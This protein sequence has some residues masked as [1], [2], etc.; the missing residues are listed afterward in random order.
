MTLHITPYPR[1]LSLPAISPNAPPERQFPAQSAQVITASTPSNAS[2]AARLENRSATGWF[3]N[4]SPSAEEL[5]SA[6]AIPLPRMTHRIVT[7]EG[8]G[9]TLHGGRIY[10]WNN[11][12]CSWDRHAQHDVAAIRLG[13]NGIAYACTAQGKLLSLTGPIGTASIDLS[14]VPMF[15]VSPTGHIIYLDNTVSGHKGL[16]WIQPMSRGKPQFDLPLPTPSGAGEPS[17]VAYS[18]DGQ[19]HLLDVDGKLWLANPHDLANS[20][21]SAWRRLLEPRAARLISLVTLP[22]GRVGGIAEADEAMFLLEKNGAWS[23]QIYGAPSGI[24]RTYGQFMD[25]RHNRGNV[26]LGSPLTPGSARVWKEGMSWLESKLCV[27][28]PEIEQ[29]L[30]P[31]G[32]S[33]EVALARPANVLERHANYVM[34]HY[35]VFTPRA[36]VTAVIREH[37]A[38]GE[39]FQASLKSGLESPFTM[40]GAMAR[41][42]LERLRRP[43]EAPSPDAL[44]RTL[45][46]D[47]VLENAN[48]ALDRLE[49]ALDL[50]DANGKTQ[51]GRFALQ[52]DR[53]NQLL[54][55]NTLHD[56]YQQLAALFPARE[57]GDQVHLTLARLDHLVRE[58]KL[59]FGTDQWL[60][61][62]QDTLYD[63]CVIQIGK[64]AYDLSVACNALA[65]FNGHLKALPETALIMEGNIRDYASALDQSVQSLFNP[66]F[67]KFDNFHAF[68]QE[69]NRPSL[70]L[71]LRENFSALLALSATEAVPQAVVNALSPIL[72]SNSAK[73]LDNIE[74]A[75][76]MTDAEGLVMHWKTAPRLLDAKRSLEQ[77]WSHDNT[78]YVLLDRRKWSLHHQVLRLPDNA[79]DVPSPPAAHGD[80]MDRTTWRIERLLY[81]GVYF[82]RPLPA[83]SARKHVDVRLPLQRT[84][85]KVADG[86]AGAVRATTNQGVDVLLGKLVHDQ[87][88]Y[89]QAAQRVSSMSLVTYQ[90]RM[91]GKDGNSVSLRFEQN[92][93][94]ARAQ[95]QISNMETMLTGFRNPG[96]AINRAASFQGMLGSDHANDY[97]R[98]V[99]ELSPGDSIKFDYS[100]LA[101]VDGD[102]WSH[103]WTPADRFKEGS[104][105]KVTDASKLKGRFNIALNNAPNILPVPAASIAQTRSM[106]ITKR[107]DGI[108]VTFE[109]AF[110]T[111]VQLLAAKIKWGAGEYA[112]NSVQ[113]EAGS[114]SRSALGLVYFGIEVVPAT[115]VFGV[116]SDNSLEMKLNNDEFGTIDH[117]VQ[118]LL[119]GRITPDE[120]IEAA[121]SISFARTRTK[122]LSNSLDV[123]GLMAVVGIFTP[124]EN[125][126]Q[127]FKMVLAGVQQ[128]TA[129]LNFSKSRS[130]VQGPSGV[131][132]TESGWAATTGL[133]RKWITVTEIQGSWIKALPAFNTMI[134]KA[135]GIIVGDGYEMEHKVPTWIDLQIKDVFGPHALYKTPV[136]AQTADGVLTRISYTVTSSKVF[137]FEALP[138]WEDLK[139]N[140]PDSA[141]NMQF[142]AQ[143]AHSQDLPVVA[144]MELVPEALHLLNTT[145]PF[146]QDASLAS[147]ISRMVKDVSCWRIKRLTVNSTQQYNTTLLAGLS[148]ARYKSDASNTYTTR[149]A[150]V[151]IEY[152][153]PQQSSAHVV[154]VHGDL[155]A[156]GGK[157]RFEQLD[158][159]IQS[160]LINTLYGVTERIE[161]RARRELAGLPQ[162]PPSQGELQLFADRWL[163]D[164]IPQ[165]VHLALA[166]GYPVI[167]FPGESNSWQ[168]VGIAPRHYENLLRTTLP[169]SRG[170]TSTAPLAL[171]ALMGAGACGVLPHIKPE[172]LL[173]SAVV[174]RLSQ[175]KGQALQTFPALSTGQAGNTLSVMRLLDEPQRLA[176]TAQR[177]Q[178]DLAQR[179]VLATFFPTVGGEPDWVTL[180]RVA[181][182]PEM[183][184]ALRQAI[185]KAT[186]QTLI[187][188]PGPGQA[189]C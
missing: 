63:F 71:Q 108:D 114:T 163:S 2:P 174:Q 155:T 47:R 131:E 72:H 29:Q 7:L 81:C 11:G 66:S 40:T 133:N 32:A 169:D 156:G 82:E 48:L 9:F 185:N 37:L 136:V 161:G 148:V 175:A 144:E 157:P 20:G 50:P 80:H 49:Q 127:R 4:I 8:T 46:G 93:W 52:G 141:K 85:H 75:L 61:I 139:R 69:Q 86:I 181:Q 64:M 43:G 19:L 94:D 180:M 39:K 187:R 158:K 113:T 42:E 165:G 74:R 31:R 53:C 153:D 103:N 38:V 173:G 125:L 124:P 90:S 6:D 22:N 170:G 105:P 177:K 30:V 117:V 27:F 92:L 67:R 44:L 142:T 183:L 166:Q 83:R 159:L 119:Q 171:L 51:T 25:T 121:A 154:T 18:N 91:S 62:N 178:L 54:R 111:A 24:Q 151:E 58:R 100:W 56:I 10:Q 145:R 140:S 162:V 149:R 57:T 118:Q 87:L 97:V 96:H 115:L 150:A 16:G 122:K 34:S 3:M 78:L 13:A 65:Q 28:K 12:T 70:T 152:P 147:D 36:A 33:E 186:S 35:G 189:A 14:N 60:T 120:L 137:N 23:R 129:S 73:A 76:G 99:N 123:Q 77:V 143:A 59:K 101:G 172:E 45:V 41:T 128:F 95:S 116:D 1:L 130:R 106:T 21:A 107:A 138:Q 188:R 110:K 182:T 102:G 126:S 134:G 112:A 55:N 160:D 89:E 26:T 17:A 5:P 132:T 164:A 109:N 84:W 104:H 79:N 98:I 15:A 179:H 146:L 88:C 184:A 168:Q 135:D 68:E 167:R 176:T